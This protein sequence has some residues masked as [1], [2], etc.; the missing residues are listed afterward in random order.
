MSEPAEAIVHAAPDLL[1]AVEA[2]VPMILQGC[3]QAGNLGDE[4]AARRFDI[5]MGALIAAIKKA[6]GL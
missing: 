5:T 2:A 4:D 3:H 1:R 6:K